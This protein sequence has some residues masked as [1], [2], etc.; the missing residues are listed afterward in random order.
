MPW[1]KLILGRVFALYA[2]LVFIVL[3]IPAYFLFLSIH[4]FSKGKN[5]NVYIH[6][7]FTAW[8]DIYMPM[9]FCPVSK[10]G[11]HHF[12]KD[13]TYIVVLNHN[14]LMDIPVSS[15]GIPGPNRTLGKSSF[16]KAPLFGFIYKLGSILV[17]RKNP[18][19]GA[20]SFIAMKNALKDGLHICLYP[21]GTRNKSNEPLL[22]FK[23]GA[24]KL[25]IKTKTPIM[26]GA[27]NG[28]KEILPATGP[29]FWFWPKRIEIVFS[30]AIGIDATLKEAELME[31]CRKRMLEL[32][33]E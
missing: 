7:A 10:K 4:I 12:K 14:S 15:P 1:Y 33:N 32:V 13:T 3:L 21:E 2:I 9:I 11:L 5:R 6:A 28:T 22:P 30:E 31:V 25:A 24:F 17:D 8:M 23:E 19:S 18:R 16:A 20:E 29:A 26:V 27:I